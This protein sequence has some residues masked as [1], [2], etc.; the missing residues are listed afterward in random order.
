MWIAKLG[1]KLQSLKRR[2]GS[3]FKNLFNIVP[4]SYLGQQYNT[5]DLLI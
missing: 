2:D 4:S 1:K 5:S 3:Q